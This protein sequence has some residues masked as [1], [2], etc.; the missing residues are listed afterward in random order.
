MIQFVNAKINIG[1]YVTERR[2]DGYHNLSTLFYPV[3]LTSGTDNDPAPFSDILEIV[4]ADRDSF[5]MTGRNLNIEP[6]KNLVW[7]ALMAFREALQFRGKETLPVSIT[8]SKHLPDGAGMGGGSADASFTLKMLNELAGNEFRSDE[9]EVIAERIGADCPFFIKNEPVYAEGT[10]NEFSRAEVSLAGYWAAI[11]KPKESI[12]TREAFGGITP[13]PAPIDLRE[14]VK[15][16]VS[17]WSGLIGNDFEEPAFLLHPEMKEVKDGL[18]ANGA[19]YASMSG[20]GSA[21][22]GIFPDKESAEN[23]V[24]LIQLPYTAVVKL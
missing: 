14:A 2:P 18:Y 11:V 15:L 19:L 21:F 22:Y 17:E 12:S 23:C 9:L 6:E 16:P 7:R 5:E 13:R 10:G 1:L 8:L 4:P 24:R 20:S 3:G